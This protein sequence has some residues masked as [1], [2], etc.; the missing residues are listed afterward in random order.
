[1]KKNVLILNI[2]FLCFVCA[3]QS[4]KISIIIPCHYTHAHYLVNLIKMYEQQT[5]LP[6]EIVIS[7]SRADLVDKEILKKIEDT[8][9][10]IP[11]LVVLSEETLFPGPNRNVACLHASGDVFI[12]QDAD[13]IPHPQRV[14]IIK[15]FFQRYELDHLGHAY[16][17]KN[18]DFSKRYVP[19]KV[20]FAFASDFDKDARGHICYGVPAI[21]RHV[22]EKIQWPND[23]YNEDVKF[24]EAVYRAFKNLVVVKVP[25]YFY[26]LERSS[27]KD[28]TFEEIFRYSKGSFIK[29]ICQCMRIIANRSMRFIQNL[30]WKLTDEDIFQEKKLLPGTKIYR[31]VIKN[32]KISS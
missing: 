32:N 12:T 21:A 24:N 16:E 28:R 19:A 27:S 11:V 1:M 17:E 20:P 18:K 14:E 2:L 31:A 3:G 22:F 8:P 6:D 7:L 13:D 30:Y 26:R 29:K 23:R 15:Y 25:L 5:E 10:H 4:R 9:W